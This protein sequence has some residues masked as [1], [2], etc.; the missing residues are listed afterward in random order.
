M[1][2]VSGAGVIWART[3]FR[4]M[5]GMVELACSEVRGIGSE[6]A[7]S[8]FPASPRTV[9]TSAGTAASGRA[10][11][12]ADAAASGGTSVP[13][14]GASPA[15]PTIGATPAGHPPKSNSPVLE[16][17]LTPVRIERALDDSRELFTWRAAIVA[18]QDDTR[19]VMVQ[20][21]DSPHG[22]PVLAW[23]LHD[24]WPLSWSGPVLDALASGVAL[25][26]VELAYAQLQWLNNPQTGDV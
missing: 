24:A 10:G 1:S 16:W 20:L 23:M 8:S 26:H 19:D 13:A 5:I 15:G 9:G 11:L 21:L 7:S 17:T 25:E 22:Q 14:L 2:G 12:G 4:V 6:T 3:N 18:G